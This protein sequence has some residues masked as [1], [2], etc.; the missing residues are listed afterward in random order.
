LGIAKDFVRLILPLPGSRLRKPN[1]TIYHP[2][3]SIDDPGCSTLCRH[4]E[5]VAGYGLQAR[6]DPFVSFMKLDG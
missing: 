6:L 3:V 2:P 4:P 5:L 1:I